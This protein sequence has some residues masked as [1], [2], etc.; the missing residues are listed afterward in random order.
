MSHNLCPDCGG[1]HEPV[2]GQCRGPSLVGRTLPGGLRVLER[3]GETS[4]GLLYRAEYPAQH[5]EP[6]LEVALVILER[7]PYGRAPAAASAELARLRNQFHRAPIDHPNVAAVHGWGET[8]PDGLPYVAAE[9]VRGEPLS[10]VLAAPG[11]LAFGEAVDLFVQ[12]AAGL[13]AAHKAGIIHGN[14][15]PDSIRVTRAGDG[16]PLV[17]LSPFEVIPSLRQPG[18]DS[19]ADKDVGAAYAS[20]ERLAGYT[21]DERSDV[22][23]LGAVLHHLLTGGPPGPG[24][25]GAATIPERVRAVLSQALAPAPAERFQ[26]IAAF[27]RAMEGASAIYP[28]RRRAVARRTLAL[29][30]VGMGLALAVA[31]LWLFRSSQRSAAGGSATATRAL[32]TLKAPEGAEAQ[33]APLDTARV[34]LAEPAVDSAPRPLP[35]RPARRG[36]PPPPRHEAAPPP[37]AALETAASESAALKVAAPEGRDLGLVETEPDRPPPVGE[38][39]PLVAERPSV[40]EPKERAVNRE[41]AEMEAR[42]AAGNAV[43]AYARV[44][45]SRDLSALERTYPGLTA[46][47]R[48]AWEKFFDVT[49]DLVVTLTIEQFSLTDSVVQLGVHGMYEYQNRSLHRAEHT[50]VRFG[51]TLTRGAAGWRFTAIR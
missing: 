21:L 45:E 27:A 42:A 16:R 50:P 25:A 22:F 29:G 43:A 26:T 30:A 37:A 19:P 41:V 28:G 48:A 39:V 5:S 11:G 47:E 13:K 4:A 51:A 34:V 49:R 31:G 32:P 24:S 18:A 35:P 1:S 8:W 36:S 3:L 9:L 46:R 6:P 15:S 2:A 20:P 44:L 17:K 38:P 33:P 40:E 10:E 7:G 12:T 23:S 14:L